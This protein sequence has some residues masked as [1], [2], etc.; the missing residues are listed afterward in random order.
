MTESPAESDVAR[1]LSFAIF[2]HQLGSTASARYR[3]DL[4]NEW[5]QK[6]APQNEELLRL[7]SRAA[8]CL[9]LCVTPL[10]HADGASE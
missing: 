7:R 9:G 8:E 4:A 3:F 10:G 2:H 5:L 1:W 6:N